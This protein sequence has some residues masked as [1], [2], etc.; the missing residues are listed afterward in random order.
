MYWLNGG[1]IIDSLSVSN[2]EGGG[3]GIILSN[4]CYYL[5]VNFEFNF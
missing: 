3:E 5:K 1:V 2:W 4:C